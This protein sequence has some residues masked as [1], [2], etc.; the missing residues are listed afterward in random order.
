[1]PEAL[2]ES[3]LFGHEKGAFTDARSDRLGLFQQANGG[4]LFLDEIAELPL[5]LQPKLLRALQE[6]TVRPVGG[7][8]EVPF[9]ARLLCATNVDLESA[10]RLGRF[11]EDLYYRVQVIQLDVP[12]LR[13]RGNDVLLL[14]QLFIQHFAE[15]VGLPVGGMLPAVASR[16]TAYPWPGNV[17]ELQNCMERAVTLCRYSELTLDDL[18]PKVAGAVPSFVLPAGAA[19]ADELIPMQ[20]V[21]RRH[22]L[23]VFEATGKNKSLTARILSLNRKTLYR[24]LRQYGVLQDDS[25]ADD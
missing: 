24:K 4:T 25:G 13:A 7:R 20:E 17:R 19:D 23:R 15:R 21:E 5:G 1:M 8:R 11:R 9:T 3:E 6:R 14:A 2:L 10:V 12:P 22:T 16:L 18:P